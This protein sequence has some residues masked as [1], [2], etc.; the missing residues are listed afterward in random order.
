MVDISEII[1][2]LKMNISVILLLEK[3]FLLELFKDSTVDTCLCSK[4]KKILSAPG[5]GIVHETFQIC[6]NTLLNGLS[7]TGKVRIMG[8]GCSY[9]LFCL[10]ISSGMLI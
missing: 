2:D 5:I 6:R 1:E 10:L 7:R 3:K 4:S 8:K 9:M